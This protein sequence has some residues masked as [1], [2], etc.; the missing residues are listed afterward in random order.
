MSIKELEEYSEHYDELE[1]ISKEVFFERKKKKEFL[2]KQRLM[3]NVF[4]GQAVMHKTYKN[5][6]IIDITNSIITV[7]FDNGEKKFKL[8][9]A[10]EQGFITL[11]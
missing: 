7:S 6:M 11:L 2:E 5:G 8:P 10:I 9:D 4:I 3:P 1:R